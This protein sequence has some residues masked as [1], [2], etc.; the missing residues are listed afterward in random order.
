M[1]LRCYTQYASKFKKLSSG[2]RIGKDQSTSQSQRGQYQRILQLCTIALISHPSKVMLKILQ[3]RLQQYVDRELPAVQAGFWRGRG[4]RDQI[5]N[6][7]WV[8]EKENSRKTST[9]ASLTMQKPLT[10]WTT[11]NYELWQVLKEMG[12]PDHLIYLLRNLYVGQ[13]GTVTRGC[14]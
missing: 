13:Q 11:A 8:M 5:A 6:K 9:Y 14:W 2:Q 10:V 4:T 7:R 12:V 3:G 1:M